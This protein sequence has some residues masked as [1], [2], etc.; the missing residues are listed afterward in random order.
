MVTFLNMSNGRRTNF[1]YLSN[2]VICILKSVWKLNRCRIYPPHDS[3]S[4]G[5]RR[6]HKIIFI[7]I[8]IRNIEFNL[9]NIPLKL[10]QL[11]MT[12]LILF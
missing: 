11:K 2:D 4:L 6:L 7:N 1:C 9:S 12:I 5:C 3:M 10:S 8:H